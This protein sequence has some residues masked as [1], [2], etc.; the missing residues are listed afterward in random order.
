MN[1]ARQFAG[2][3]LQLSRKARWEVPMLFP[4][5]HDF[6][7]LKLTDRAKWIALFCDRESAGW[8]VPFPLLARGEST[9]SWLEDQFRRAHQVPDRSDRLREAVVDLILREIVGIELRRPDHVLGVLVEL[10]GSCQFTEVGPKVSDWIRS[11]HFAESRYE[12]GGHSV[13]LR[14]TLWGIVIA[15]GLSNDMLPFLKRDL[16]IASFEC[17]AL[18]FSALGR[19]SPFDAIAEI[20]ATY[21]WHAAYRNEVLQSFFEAYYGAGHVLIEPGLLLAWERCLGELRW[22]PEISE[23]F[24][25]YAEDFMGVLAMAGLSLSKVKD[26]EKFWLRAASRPFCELYVDLERNKQRVDDLII[27]NYKSYLLSTSTS[28][29]PYYG[30][31]Q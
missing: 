27:S 22:N 7:D 3:L 25:G 30:I 28:G 24:Q 17:G 31:R 11:D 4:G 5:T 13:P 23:Q 8:Q 26:Q 29:A 21:G 6:L 12:V 15:W 2:K 9:L 10:A 14:Q 1:A 18:C 19:L 20:P 16:N